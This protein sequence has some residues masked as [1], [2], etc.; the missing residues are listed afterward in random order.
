[1]SVEKHKKSLNN[2]LA[3]MLATLDTM[4][5][6][7]QDMAAE[8]GSKQTAAAAASLTQRLF[9]LNKEL[10]QTE[11]EHLALQKQMAAFVNNNEQLLEILVQRFDK[12]GCNLCVSRDAG[13]DR[14]LYRI[15]YTTNRYLIL[16][17][18]DGQLS[19]LDMSPTH[20][21]FSSI[22]EFF[23]ESQD[24]IGLLTSFGSAK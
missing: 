13:D 2:Q 20:P 19:L 18:E 17:V 10:L 21:N 22:K 23:R 3:N 4:S 9:E 16:R 11:S 7:M 12:L 24:L 5:C 6:N 1:M 14:T 8:S 15:D